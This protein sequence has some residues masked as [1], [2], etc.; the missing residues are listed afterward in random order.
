[1]VRVGIAV[2]NRESSYPSLSTGRL[3]FVAQAVETA[4]R[5]QRE[6]QA[7]SRYRLHSVIICSVNDSVSSPCGFTTASDLVVATT[8]GEQY[9]VLV[10][11]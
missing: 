4:S 9:D 7:V 8:H 10:G 6:C 11:S 2:E 5:L 1:M 3:M